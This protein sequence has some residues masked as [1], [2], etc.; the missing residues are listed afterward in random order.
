MNRPLM[1]IVFA[2]VTAFGQKIEIQKLDRNKITRM[3]TTQN[4][5]SVIELL[6]PV[7]QVAAGSSSFKIE[8]RENKVFIQPLEPEATTNLFI[9]TASGRLSYE[10]VPADS[11]Q[12]MHFAID[13]DPGT[14]QARTE[15]LV[16]H[17]TAV[18]QP[19]VPAAMLMESMPVK[20]IGSSKNHQK[21]AIVLQDVYRKDGRVYLRYAIVNGGR[22]VYLPAAPEVFTLNSPRAPQSLIPLANSQLTADYQLK[23]KDQAPVAVVH[24]E[25][26]A[27]V[28]R[29]GQ[30]ARGVVAFELPS[31]N[32]QGVRT[33]VKL[34]FPADLAGPV[35]AV[36]VL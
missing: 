13:Q 12:Q 3:G 34:A 7:T 28:V 35:S 15:K 2:T 10:L 20:P 32:E 29:P 31:P 5:L 21:V 16:E 33:V 36:L 8:W 27:P 26:Q 9:W 11:V 4:H 18:E 22:T 23:W 6:E 14:I 1:L 25:I 19:K 24:T 30:T 17:A